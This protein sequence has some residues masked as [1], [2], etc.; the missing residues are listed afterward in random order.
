[1][2]NVSTMI[3]SDQDSMTP[4]FAGMSGQPASSGPFT[5]TPEIP[6]NAP[7]TYSPDVPPA[8]PPPQQPQK[9]AKARPEKIVGT[10]QMDSTPISDLMGPDPTDYMGG[11]P[12]QPM[13]GQQQ[14][15]AV[16]P[17]K[18]G[19]TPEQMDALLAGVAA[20]IA[21]AK[22]VQ[23]KLV[24]FIPQMVGAGGETSTMGLLITALVAALIFY[25]GRRFVVK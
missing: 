21:F 8:P 14:Q 16:A 24:G 1:M 3:L 18:G 15:Q 4:L 2:E 12:S 13:M 22:P 6:S 9:P 5:Y 20:V 19:L 23:E 7:F 10:P 17:R 25:F 11:A